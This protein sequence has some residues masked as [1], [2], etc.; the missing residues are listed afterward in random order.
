MCAIAGILGLDVSQQTLDNMLASM[1]RRG[2]DGKGSYQTRN[3]CLIHTRLAII[4][5][6]GGAQPMVF[7]RARS[8]M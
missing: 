8:V 6:S 4:D 7:D 3:L 1:R 5:P 2:P